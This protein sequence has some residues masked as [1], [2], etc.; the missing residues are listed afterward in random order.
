MSKGTETHKDKNN[1][2]QT[3]TRNQ[4]NPKPS[5]LGVHL[6]GKLQGLTLL[7]NLAWLSS[8]MLDK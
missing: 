1:Q 5:Q 4:T 8:E 6:K 7:L 3:T 2:Q